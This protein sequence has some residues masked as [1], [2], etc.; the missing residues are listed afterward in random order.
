MMMPTL[1][2]Y[3]RLCHLTARS[4]VYSFGAWRQGLCFV[5]ASLSQDHYR[6]AFMDDFS[7][8]F[9]Q[10]LLECLMTILAR[11]RSGAEQSLRRLRSVDKTRPSK[12]QSLVDWA[13]PKLNDNI[14]E[15]MMPT[16]DTYCRLCT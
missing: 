14:V 11:A 10:Y 13:R 15:M 3:C 8:E 16:L 5:I 7:Q 9:F 4:D 6:L 12:E 1:D 2:T